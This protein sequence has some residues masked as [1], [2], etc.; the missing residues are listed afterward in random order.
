MPRLPASAVHQIPLTHATDAA[1]PAAMWWIA[2]CIDDAPNCAA[3]GIDPATG[4]V[5]T[6]SIA[7]PGDIVVTQVTAGDGAVFMLSNGYF[8]APFHITRVDLVTGKAE[9][10]V[11]VPF[12]SVTGDPRGKLV[13]GA[14][15]LWFSEGLHPIA[16]FSPIDGSLEGAVTLPG[17]VEDHLDPGFVVNAHGVFAIGGTTGTSVMRIDPTTR[18]VTMVANFGGG[19]TQSVAADDRS[20]WTTHYTSDLD[21]VRI[22]TTAGFGVK[23]IGIPTT[24]VATGEGQIWFIG[25]V[26]GMKTTDPANHFGVVGRIDPTTGR[27]IAVTEL[28]MKPYDAAFLRVQGGN[29]YVLDVTTAL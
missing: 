26:P 2:G 7:V 3:S 14:N 16:E 9:W 23:P 11:P 28:P 27:V 5:R 13:F 4:R 1:N 20:V 18:R 21:L 6:L 12:T 24:Y 8:G 15:A 25:Y 22:D 19:Y 29:A 10:T 17:G